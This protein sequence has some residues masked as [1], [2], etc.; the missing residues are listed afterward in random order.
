MDV[1]ANNDRMPLHL[2][3]VKPDRNIER[4]ATRYNLETRNFVVGF[5]DGMGP[6]SHQSIS[7]DLY[8]N[9]KNL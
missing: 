4:L 1:I 3:Q 6:K 8:N 7:R 5:G 9:I 2:R